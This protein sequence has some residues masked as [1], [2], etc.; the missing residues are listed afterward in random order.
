MSV[1]NRASK[2]QEE[3][4]NIP[5]ADED[6]QDESEFDT[7]VSASSALATHS[8]ES[9]PS[10]YTN[11]SNSPALTS[12]DPDMSPDEV[13]EKARLISQVLELQNTLDGARQGARSED[14]GTPS[15]VC[16]SCIVP[17]LYRRTPPRASPI[18]AIQ[19]V[20]N[21]RQQLLGTVVPP[22]PPLISMRVASALGS[23]RK[24]YQ[25]L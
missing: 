16:C 24:F 9:I 4:N 2:F 7:S 18:D 17:P 20:L 10:T 25:F 8:V 22:C 13:E 21:L 5:L 23:F 6:A 14:S 12:L 19:C 15:C 11:G 1:A 3:M